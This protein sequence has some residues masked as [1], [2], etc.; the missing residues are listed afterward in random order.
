[1]AL[2][3]HCDTVLFAFVSHTSN[4]QFIVI[5][6]IPPSVSLRGFHDQGK[7]KILY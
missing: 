3:V 4:D 2:M 7:N 6:K 1:M 5:Q